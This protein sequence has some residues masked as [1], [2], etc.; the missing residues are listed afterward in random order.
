MKNANVL[1]TAAV[2]TLATFA[3]VTGRRGA[4]SI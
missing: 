4:G 2:A 1:R 3:L